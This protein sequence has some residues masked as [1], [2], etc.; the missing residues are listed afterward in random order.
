MDIFAFVPQNLCMYV[1]EAAIH[2]CVTASPVRL[3]WRVDLQQ[4]EGI[5]GEAIVR[6]LGFQR[7]DLSTF[8]LPFHSFSPSSGL[9]NCGD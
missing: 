2:V 6:G 4:Q 7:R 9:L 5:L 3:A 1:H 8:T